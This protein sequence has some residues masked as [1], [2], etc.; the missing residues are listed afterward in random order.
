MKLT[1]M[2]CGQLVREHGRAAYPHALGRVS[3]E[4]TKMSDI[5]SECS[6]PNVGEPYATALRSSVAFV[7]GEV[8]AV[9]IV[10]TGTIIRGT[11][12]Q[13]SDL[14]LYVIHNEPFRRRVQRFFGERVPTEIFINPPS[15]IRAYFVEENEAGRPCTAHM[16]ATGYVVF[17]RGPDVKQL[18]LEAKE[19]LERPSFPNEDATIRARYDAAIRLE[20][21]TDVAREDS[22]TSSLLMSQ[23]VICNAGARPVFATLI[24]LCTGAGGKRDR[25]TAGARR[26]NQ[27]FNSHRRP[28][29]S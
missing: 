22:T 15:A 2:S 6:W 16:L 29:K 13:S 12:H 24:D 14:D 10:A 20:D 4:G 25:G 27:L 17:E 1:R 7:C 19:W 5:L 18:R 28:A 8:N 23:A 3:F 26:S 21:A 11:S 9:G